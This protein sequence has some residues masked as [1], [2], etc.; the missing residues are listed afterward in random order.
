MLIER[1]IRIRPNI[2]IRNFG[3]INTNINFLFITLQKFLFDRF[4]TTLELS[5]FK[6]Y[7]KCLNMR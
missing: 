4:Q 6:I 3:Y 5:Q 1:Y 7:L 2:K